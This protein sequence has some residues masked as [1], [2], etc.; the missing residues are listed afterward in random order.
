MIGEWR[1]EYDTA[2]LSRK[3]V[4]GNNTKVASG[5]WESLPILRLLRLGGTRPNIRGSGYRDGSP[6]AAFL[7]S[8]LDSHD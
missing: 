4:T 7:V 1:T 6:L 5:F 8:I 2:H 3:E